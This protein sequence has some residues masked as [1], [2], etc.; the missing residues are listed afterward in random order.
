MTARMKAAAIAVLIVSAW[1]SLWTIGML[2]RAVWLLT[3]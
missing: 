3:D 1:L 2:I